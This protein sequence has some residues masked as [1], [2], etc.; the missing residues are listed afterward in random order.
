VENGSSAP[1]PVND[2]VIR[3]LDQGLVTRCN[4]AVKRGFLVLIACT[5]AL[6]GMAP[7][8]MAAGA[9]RGFLVSSAIRSSGE[10]CL[11]GGDRALCLI[12]RDPRNKT[13]CHGDCAE[14]WPPL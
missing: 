9:K 6:A 14:A 5:I 10:C 12:T 2:D 11:S 8:A 13:C 7:E 1:L 4:G 3:S